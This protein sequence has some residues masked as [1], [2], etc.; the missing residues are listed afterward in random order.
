MNSEEEDRLEK[1]R[2]YLS[3]KDVHPQSLEEV[4]HWEIMSAKREDGSRERLGI[5][6]GRFVDALD[7]SI[8]LPKFYRSPEAQAPSH[9]EDGI[10]QRISVIRIEPR[11]YLNNILSDN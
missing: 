9:E 7:F 11:P 4:Y 2:G 6:G 10:V 8:D 5:L 1:I 3:R